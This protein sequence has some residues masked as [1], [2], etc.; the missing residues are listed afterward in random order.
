MAGRRDRGDR[1]RPW[2]V[3]MGDL[4]VIASHRTDLATF[5]ALPVA[6][7][8]VASPLII[9][10]AK[11]TKPGDSGSGRTL[12]GVADLLAGAVK[13]QWTHAATERRL[14]HPEPIPV[15]WDR[16]SQ[17]V[18]G[19]VSAAA[20]SQQFPPLPGLSAVRQSRL[21]KGGLPDLQA[22]YGGLGSGRMVIVGAPGSGKSGAAVL[23]VLAALSGWPRKFVGGQKSG[24][25]PIPVRWTVQAVS[26]ASW[27]VPVGKPVSRT[28]SSYRLRAA[29]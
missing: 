22:V 10:L 29:E 4:A 21:R 15:R 18:V 24:S 12:D 20:K 28:A 6:I 5:W 8:A 7:I 25:C 16:P 23:L 11:R 19:P 27:G 14:L 3:R 2:R 13:D 26:R 17:P 9:Y 1:C